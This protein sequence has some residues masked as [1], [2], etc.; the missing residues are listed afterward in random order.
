[1]NREKKLS[2]SPGAIVSLSY[3]GCPATIFETQVL[4][5]FDLMTYGS[6]YI[7]F[8][9]FEGQG[10]HYI[11]S[12]KRASVLSKKY[13]AKLSCHRA[14]NKFLPGSIFVNAL[15]L[16]FRNF[17]VLR[18]ASV[19]HA[20]TEYAAVV[21]VRL[22]WLFNYRVV[23]DIR[24][25][26][27]D[28]LRL[29]GEQTSSWLL[30]FYI[31]TFVLPRQEMMLHFACR[32]SDKIRFVSEA[33]QALV[34]KKY[35]ARRGPSRAV[36]PCGADTDRFYFDEELRSTTRGFLGVERY[37]V[38]LYSGSLAKYQSISEVAST[39]ESLMALDEDLFVIVATPECAAAAD[40]FKMLPDHRLLI[41]TFS[42]EEMNGVY[43]AADFGILL[44]EYRD[45]NFVAVPTK[46]AEYCVTGLRCLHNETV[47]IVCRHSEA[48]ESVSVDL[49]P[50]MLKYGSKCDRGSIARRGAD[51]FSTV[52][53]ETF[54]FEY[55]CGLYKKSTTTTS[56]K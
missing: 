18:K 51:I 1:M 21:A 6:Q 25:D 52:R 48:L 7:T 41:K 43:N 19:V 30:K 33:L 46:Y 55:L 10:S 27:V 42:L 40:A 20:R 45:L 50:R 12:K 23:A 35:F 26:T 13:A 16:V 3:E 4:N 38:L 44:R 11:D 34:C 37:T 53:S 15:L 17:R 22:R 56:D 39:L 24:G 31:S 47:D 14:F 8:L 32:S 29:S 9:A 54:W 2:P 49:F 5:Q 36:I 28:E